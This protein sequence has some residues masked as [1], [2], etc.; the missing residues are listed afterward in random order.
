MISDC[1]Q[2]KE[3]KINDKRCGTCY[4]WSYQPIDRVFICI[5]RKS[6]AMGDWTNENDVCHEWRKGK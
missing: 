6:G 3:V 1:F 4:Y 2:P 5:C